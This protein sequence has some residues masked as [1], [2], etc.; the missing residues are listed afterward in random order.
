MSLAD[1]PRPPHQE[2]L[3]RQHLSRFLGVTD[4]AALDAVCERLRWLDLAGGEALIRQG[5]AGDALFMLVSGRLRAYIDEPDG[6]PRRMVRE[7]ARGE[8][9]GEMSLFTGAPRSATVVALRDSVLV[10]LDRADFHE[11]LPLRPEVTLALTRQ[12]I[13]RLQTERGSTLI[14]SPVAMALVP[15]TAGVDSAGLAAALAAALPAGGRVAVLDRARV[16]ALLGPGSLDSQASGGVEG[17]RR[18]VAMLLDEVESTHDYVLL[19]GDDTA[20]DWTGLCL[21]HAD[22][23]LLLADADAPPQLHDSERRFLL[24]R[25]GRG[26][27]AE[28]LVLLHPADRPMPRGT[29][30]WLARRPVSGHLHVRPALARDI[31]RLARFQSRQAVGLVLAGGGARGFAHLGV[32]RALQERGIEV[33]CV[34]GT[35]IGAVM[36]TLAATDQPFEQVD[37]V[38]R[39]AF[40]TNPTGDFTLLPFVSLIKGRRLRRVVGEAVQRAV[41]EGAGI[42]DL[43]KPFF[44]VATNYSQASE[45]VLERGPLLQAILASIAIPGALPPVLR[46]GEL[47]CDGGTFNNF[48]VD[49]MRRQRGVGRVIGVD[50]SADPPRRID[51]DEMPDGWALLRDRLRQRKRRRFR[52]PSL[53][54]LLINAT[55]LYSQS[56]QK[57]A[58]TLTDLYFNPPLKRVGMLDWSRYDEVVQLG[59]EHACALLDGSAGGPAP[60]AAA[61]AAP[62]VSTDAPLS[63]AAMAATARR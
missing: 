4:A 21:R 5:E 36:A 1:L 48:P 59:Y 41:G 39:P 47:L 14:D 26:E 57:Q 40:A 2:D 25:A 17:A 16:E 10:A 15:V 45:L 30:A 7:I 19:V 49:V 20:S 44:C 33:D 13:Q 60:T 50:L 12:V 3:L 29:A 34:G 6:G 37:R 22:E 18:R 58:R 32:L 28:I 56:R 42:E 53:P 63:P 23:I 46:D 8:V 35:S 24:D 38:A 11:L 31:A 55:I 43:W 9:V 62:A 51:L 61:S 54:T 27:A 52:L